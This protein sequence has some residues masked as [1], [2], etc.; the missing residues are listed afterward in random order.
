MTVA[1]TF[2]ALG[3]GMGLVG[4]TAALSAFLAGRIMS[5]AYLSW[6]CRGVVS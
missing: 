2:V 3:W 4:V 5:T 1:I 6:G